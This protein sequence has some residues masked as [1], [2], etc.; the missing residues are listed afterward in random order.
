MITQI[1]NH[2]LD[3]RKPTNIPAKIDRSFNDF[4]MDGEGNIEFEKKNFPLI[5]RIDLYS[6]TY[7]NFNQKDLYINEF[8]ML[9]EYTK[10]KDLKVFCQMI[11][12]IL[13]KLE[14]RS[15]LVFFGD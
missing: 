12:D 8:S 10:S 4:Q 1:Y 7:I 3:I 14:Y 15:F 2:T 13:K 11:I 5:S 9:L 6:D